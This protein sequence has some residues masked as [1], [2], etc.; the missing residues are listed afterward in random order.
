MKEVTRSQIEISAEYQDAVREM[1]SEEVKHCLSSVMQVI[2]EADSLTGGD[3]SEEIYNVTSKPYYTLEFTYTCESKDCEE[4]GEEYQHTYE[5]EE[6]SADDVE[7][8]DY[9][10]DCPCCGVEH[11]P[12]SVETLDD[13][14]HEALEFWLVSDWLGRRL[15][16]Q[17]EMVEMDI[18]GMTVWG[19]CTSGQ[20]IL[21]DGVICRI[22]DESHKE[23]LD[24]I[25]RDLAVKGG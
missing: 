4:K 9:K 20:A 3:Y 17:G 24:I 10:D 18:Y 7:L 5:E 23:K 19:R 21:L 14:H 6:F 15:K 25:K 16:E 2:S 22:F 13:G 12:E 11:E 8:D 1:V